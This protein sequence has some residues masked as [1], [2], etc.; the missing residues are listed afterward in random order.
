MKCDEESRFSSFCAL[1]A[2]AHSAV[3]SVRPLSDT[4]LNLHHTRIIRPNEYGSE[5][6]IPCSFFVYFFF[7]VFSR[8]GGT[9][10]IYVKFLK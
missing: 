10:F 4:A 1:Q 7:L 6:K 9:D 8:A 3:P 5:K 2:A